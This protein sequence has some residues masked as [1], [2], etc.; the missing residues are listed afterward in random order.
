MT[1]TSPLSR[2]VAVA[3]AALLLCLPALWNGLPFFYPDT[4]TYLR[5][6]EMAAGQVA[7]RLW[8]TQTT[9]TTQAAATDDAPAPNTAAPTARGLTSLSDKI[10]LAGRSIYY[11]A[12]LY[13]AQAAGS[14]WLGVIAQA[15]CVAAVLHLMMVTLWRVRPAAYLATVAALSLTT[16]LGVYSAL[17]MPDVFAGL[18]LLALATLAVY[19]RQ[20]SGVARGLLLGVLLFGLLGHASHV[21]VVA[22]LLLGALALRLWNPRWQGLSAPALTGV[23]VCL[24]LAV[25]AEWAFAAGVQR[26]MGVPPLRLPYPTA[27]L[28]EMGPG[29]RFLQARCPDAGYAVCAY[30]ANYPTAW[31][32]FL[33]SDDPA[34]GSFALADAD[35]KRRIVAQQGDFVRA[36][37]AYDPVGVLVGWVTDLGRQLLSFRVD[38]WSFGDRQLAM[39]EGRVPP[40]TLQ[41]MQAS[42]GLNAPAYNH[43]LSAM[44]YAS[45]LAAVVLGVWWAWRRRAGAPARVPQRLEQVATLVLAGVATNALV[46]VTA[47]SSLDRFQ[48]RVIWLLPFLALTAL[49]WSASR[50]PVAQTPGL[51]ASRGPSARRLEGA[52]S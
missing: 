30:A 3:C 18:T 26:A 34:R 48:S 17:L 50:N 39:Y 24:V 7:K 23:A 22:V 16:P 5:G 40:Q 27:R 47:A 2:L 4:P 45:T 52:A 28:I 43:V 14:W 32:A 11:G 25:A 10:V 33:F 6:A 29:T 21:A 37:I 20:L 38:V 9:Q 35:T 46:C 49:A 13:A 31:D 19:W 41:A 44:T 12:L 8:P 1:T 15:L 42:K 51:Q 36:V